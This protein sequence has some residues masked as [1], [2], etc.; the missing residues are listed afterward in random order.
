MEERMSRGGGDDGDDNGDGGGGD[1][2]GMIDEVGEN[3]TV[4]CGGGVRGNVS[5]RLL[6]GHAA[7]KRSEFH[8]PCS[9]PSPSAIVTV[10][11]TVISIIFFFSP[12]FHILF[13]FSI[14]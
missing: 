12:L 8:F 4:V 2:R 5:L 9:L 1:D 7:I 10:I 14:S 11:V 3:R 6:F 13:F